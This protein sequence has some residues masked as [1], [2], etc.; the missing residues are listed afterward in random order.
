MNQY[1]NQNLN[2]KSIESPEK[3]AKY[4]YL[5]NEI[6][7]QGNRCLELDDRNTIRSLWVSGELYSSYT[8]SATKIDALDGRQ[9]HKDVLE[10]YAYYFRREFKYDVPG[11]SAKEQ[12]VKYNCMTEKHERND[13]VGWLFN[14]P[15]S[16]IKDSI[17]MVK[18]VGGCLF[19][20]QEYADVPPG[21]ALCWI[22]LHPY[23]LR[24]GILSSNWDMFKQ[25]FGDFYVEPPFSD[26]MR[27]F[28][29]KVGYNHLKT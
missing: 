27:S 14:S 20:Y 10:V 25:E 1:L 23:H 29:E 3:E 18:T 22:W 19:R 4:Q 8:P 24:Q 2:Q 16:L 13:Y 5:F 6:D 12:F 21:W 9:C 7:R 28:L 17:G 26:A 15:D 11:F